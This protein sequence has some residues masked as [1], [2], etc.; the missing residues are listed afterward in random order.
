MFNLITIRFKRIGCFKY[1]VYNI[2]VV[3]KCNRAKGRFLEKIG[4]YNPQNSENFFFINSL[5]LGF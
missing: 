3:Y 5:R 4:F 1:P 2:V